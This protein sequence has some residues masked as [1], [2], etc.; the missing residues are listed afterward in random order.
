VIPEAAVEAAAMAVCRADEEWSADDYY[1]RLATAALEAAAPHMFI[2]VH[3]HDIEHHA[4]SFNEGYETAM[5]QDL[6]VNP[7][8]AQD[9]L[10][11]KLAEAW[12]KGMQAMYDTTSSEWPPI[13]E[14]NP[15]RSQT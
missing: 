13:P 3:H 4:R 12:D 10:D 1:T 7:S 14:A 9:W 6:A 8:L 5:A 2:H 11:E 15:Y